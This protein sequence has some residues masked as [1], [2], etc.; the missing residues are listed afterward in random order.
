MEKE[1]RGKEK[2]RGEGEE[3]ERRGDRKRKVGGS[4]FLTFSF[5]PSLFPKPLL[6]QVSHLRPPTD[7]CPYE[8]L[9][10]ELER[11]LLM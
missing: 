8:L 4:N 9:A 10:A 3:R 5:F 1:R 7:R 6:L 2:R 11:E